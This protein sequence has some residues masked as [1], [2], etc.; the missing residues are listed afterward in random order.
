M[1]AF[2]L[3]AVSL[4][5]LVAAAG[6]GAQAASFDCAK[7]TTRVEKEICAS[8]HLS[9]LDSELNAL[10]Q[11]LLKP[12][13]P[14]AAAI[15]EAQRKWL[16]ETRAGAANPAEL[17][18]VYENQAQ[19]LRTDIEHM[20]GDVSHILTYVGRAGQ[21]PVVAKMTAAEPPAEENQ[22]ASEVA[23]ASVPAVGP[24]VVPA[25]EPTAG[26]QPSATA[27][28]PP[29][30]PVPT[31]PAPMPPAADQVPTPAAFGATQAALLFGI[32]VLAGVGF[33]V[34]ASRRTRSNILIG[35]GGVLV[36]LTTLALMSTA[37]GPAQ[38][39]QTPITA[40]P[41]GPVAAPTAAIKPPL[42]AAPA[43]TDWPQALAGKWTNDA[44]A[45]P[46]CAGQGP[47]KF[48]RADG[49]VTSTDDS[50]RIFNHTPVSERV[51]KSFGNDIAV[52]ESRF[53]SVLTQWLFRLQ[54]STL[55]RQPL[56]GAVVDTKEQALAVLRAPAP[57]NKYGTESR[58]KHHRCG[59]DFVV[60]LAAME[61]FQP[62]VNERFIQKVLKD[63]PSQVFN[64]QPLAN[65]VF[66][67][68]TQMMFFEHVSARCEPYVEVLRSAINQMGA[69]DMTRPGG[70]DDASILQVA[71]DARTKLLLASCW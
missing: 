21:E 32:P 65:E 44:G 46:S 10:Y 7:A 11:F 4:L 40:P 71:D 19:G 57:T 26:A 37:W 8:P 28:A 34:T 64:R 50:G 51:V 1:L 66:R 24:P 67:K 3:A 2:K 63:S 17:V 18:V 20:G 70:G 43:P 29:A 52:V 41:A 33:G 49:R 45:A 16:R 15:R 38:P 5:V 25:P 69:M 62:E 27:A 48:V 55:V 60:A 30:L 58:F 59:G 12:G 47:Y 68:A 39:K 14:D 31:L 54:G 23:A 61:S 13:Q 35:G 22:P 53:G 56:D 36:A 9:N 42:P 6:P